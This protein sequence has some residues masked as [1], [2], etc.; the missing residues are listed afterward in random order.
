[1][2][3]KRSNK[4]ALRRQDTDGWIHTRAERKT[5]RHPLCYIPKWN[6]T[7]SLEVSPGVSAA[8]MSLAYGVTVHQI[9]SDCATPQ[10]DTSELGEQKHSC[11]HWKHGCTRHVKKKRE[12]ETEKGR[13]RRKKRGKVS[14]EA[15]TMHNNTVVNKWW[16]PWVRILN[17]SHSHAA[18]LYLTPNWVWVQNLQS[19]SQSIAHTLRLYHCVCFLPAGFLFCWTSAAL[20]R[21]YWC[22]FYFREPHQSQRKVSKV[23]N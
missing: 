4:K 16:A 11:L 23:F 2:G 9:L 14:N 10:S 1:M 3:S 8:R 20:V 7:P 13:K 17:L 15:E 18:F 19:I 12:R 21:K 22:D 6:I 5:G